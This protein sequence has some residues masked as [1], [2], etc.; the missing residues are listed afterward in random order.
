MPSGLIIY[1]P[2]GEEPRRASPEEQAEFDAVQKAR[3]EEQVEK[4]F[5][6]M[7]ERNAA[8]E[9]KRELKK[10]GLTPNK[11]R[12]VYAWRYRERRGTATRFESYIDR[13]TKD[14]DKIP[15]TLDMMKDWDYAPPGEGTLWR[16]GPRLNHSDLEVFDVFAVRRDKKGKKRRRVIETNFKNNCGDVSCGKESCAICW[17]VNF[18][19]VKEDETIVAKRRDGPKPRVVDPSGVH[20]KGAR[21]GKAQDMGLDQRAP[22]NLTS[23]LYSFKEGASNIERSVAFPDSTNSRKV[24]RP[25]S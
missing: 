5:R 19:D 9:L 4:A 17:A 6:G 16:E 22:F 7:D 18:A 21:T 1:G 14:G 8:R 10:K 24:R 25:K 13:E 23:T 12:S 2:D 15:A 20:P 3:H 11:T